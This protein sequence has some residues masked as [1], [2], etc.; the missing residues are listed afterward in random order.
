[1]IDD[2]AHRRLDDVDQKL[3][4]HVVHIKRLEAA[5]VKNTSSLGENTKLTQE[6]ATNTAELVE[7]FKGA[8]S[9][10]KFAFWVA[11]IVALAFAVYHWI[12]GR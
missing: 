2:E 12:V 11:P 3:L 5:I 9:F 7:L 6:I 4:D 10:R 1:M 8:K